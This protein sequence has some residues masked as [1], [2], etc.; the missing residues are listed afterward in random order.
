MMWYSS[1]PRTGE[2]TPLLHGSDP[3]PEHTAFM[4]QLKVHPGRPDLY[5]ALDE[6]CVVINLS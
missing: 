5:K 4:S 3:A 6:V 1:P 2:T